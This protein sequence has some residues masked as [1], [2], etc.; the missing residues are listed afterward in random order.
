MISQSEFAKL[1]SSVSEA[2]GITPGGAA[3]AMK[4]LHPADVAMETQGVPMPDNDPIVLQQY[5]Q[6]FTISP[7]TGTEGSWSSRLC[8]LPTIISFGGYCNIAT[9][10][11]SQV[12]DAGY[13]INQQLGVD[14]SVSASDQC[15]ACLTQIRGMVRK[16]RISNFSVTVTLNATSTTD[17][18]VVVAAPVFLYRDSLV[19][20]GASGKLMKELIVTEP[21]IN[22]SFSAP[23]LSGY[24]NSYTGQARDGI[25]GVYRQDEDDFLYL[26][27]S[28]FVLSGLVRGTIAVAGP[29]VPYNE[30]LTNSPNTCP[31]PF[32]PSGVTVVGS[33]TAGVGGGRP[34]P[35][36]RK[37]KA[38][39]LAVTGLN[40]L[41]TM[42]VKVVCGFEAVPI[43]GSL[44]TPLMRPPLPDDPIAR[45]IYAEL[46]RKLPPIMPASY[47]LFGAILPFLKNVGSRLV[48]ALPTV[49]RTLLQAVVPP[50]AGQPQSTERLAPR[51]RSVKQPK[52][53][54][55][56]RSKKVVRRAKSKPKA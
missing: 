24:S 25:Y 10:S 30:I 32:L 55:S 19:P 8:L 21:I 16:V 31:H 9:V 56:S 28:D 18:G 29:D 53:R 13:L 40:P 12:F 45:E 39:V 49:G 42:S 46:S 35:V 2:R 51:E 33:T 17:S 26:D 5:T 20:F 52:E 3:W 48:G 4:A 34:Y 27:T 37:L 43:V 1:I 47:N 7:P 6:T 36:P 54:K 15:I 11:G 50:A 23:V 14:T 41:A 22:P 44:W 38:F